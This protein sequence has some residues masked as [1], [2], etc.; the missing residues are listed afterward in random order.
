MNLYNFS[1]NHSCGL[2]NYYISV[3]SI[4]F[5]SQSGL[6]YKVVRLAALLIPGSSPTNAWIDVCKYVDKTVQQPC[7]TP[8]GQ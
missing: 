8:R 3:H 6:A 2:L 1:N 5:H 4:S 7:W